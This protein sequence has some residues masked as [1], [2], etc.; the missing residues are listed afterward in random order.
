MN[1]V[2]HFVDEHGRSAFRVFAPRAHHLAVLLPDSGLR[3]P[4]QHDS[5]GYW[6]GS[7]DRLPAGTLYLRDLDG[8]H[9]PDPASRCQP[10]GVHGPSMV[11]EVGPSRLWCWGATRGRGLTPAPDGSD[12]AAMNTTHTPRSLPP[13]AVRLQAL[14]DLRDRL[15]ALNAELAYLRLMLRLR[16]PR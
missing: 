1:E 15:L 3:I 13:E 12:D 2:G 7:S 9:L 10:Q 14:I 4:L 6:T 11:V 16:A 5:I 8:R